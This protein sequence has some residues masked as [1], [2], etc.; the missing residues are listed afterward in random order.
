MAMEAVGRCAGGGG[1]E[2]RRQFRDIKGIM[3]GRPSPTTRGR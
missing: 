2:V 1:E 3:E